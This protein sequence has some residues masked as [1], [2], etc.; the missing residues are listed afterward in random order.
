[1]DAV[2]GSRENPLPRRGARV[3][4]VDAEGRL[5]LLRGSDPGRPGSRYWY[6]VGGGLEA[7]ETPAAGAVRE[8]F[9]E[10]GLRAE[11]T[12]LGEPLFE[13]VTDFPYDGTWYRQHQWFYL[14][15]VPAYDV[16][17]DW[18][19]AG[20]GAPGGLEE[21]S[22]DEY[23]WWTLDELAGTDEKVYPPDLAEV[24]RGIMGGSGDTSGRIGSGEGMGGIGTTAP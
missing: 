2:V 11:P 18:A 7:G 14:L 6:T 22:I 13:D 12:D 9:E 19:A 1:M 15:R 24:L 20:S 17:A 10:A 8:L 16:P 4:V 21:H 3:L 5:L 23:R